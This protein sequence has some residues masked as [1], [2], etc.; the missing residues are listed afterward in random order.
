MLFVRDRRIMHLYHGTLEPKRYRHEAFCHFGTRNAA[1]ERIAR[2]L[3]E[4][5]R[6]TPK[7]LKVPFNFKEV[8][9]LQISEDWGSNQ[10]ISLARVMKDHFE[11]KD[12]NAYE[13][14][15]NIRTQ[16]IQNKA[17]GENYREKGVNMLLN[18]FEHMNIKAIQYP[19]S[20][21]HTGEDSFCI[22]FPTRR[23]CV[24]VEIPMQFEINRKIAA[25]K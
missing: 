14:F 18:A 15:E 19:N 11:K 25:L 22:I 5:D 1:L 16:L 6:G 20:V 2:R 23:I 9:I 3:H 12:K 8:E 13:K 24:G 7:I 10:P 17:D 21:E 4:G